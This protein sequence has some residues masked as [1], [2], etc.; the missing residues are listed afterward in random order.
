MKRKNKRIKLI[1]YLPNQHTFGGT[2]SFIFNLLKHLNKEQFQPIILSQARIKMLAIFQSINIPIKILNP[3]S[4]HGMKRLIN[5]IKEN[6]IS[7][8]QTNHFSTELA[9]ASYVAGI[10]HIWRPGGDIRLTK[11]F[12]DKKRRL[13]YFKILIALSNK[14]VCAS[15]FLKRQFKDINCSEIKVIYNGVEIKK[16]DSRM[17]KNNNYAIGMIAHLIPQKKHIDFIRAAEI[18][19]KELP[20]TKFY[21]I[22]SPYYSKESINYARLLKKIVKRKKLRKHIIFTGFINNPNKVILSLNATVMPS[23]DEGSSNAIIESLAL[24][25]P[26]IASRSGGNPELIADNINGFLVKPRN[27]IGLANSIIKILKNPKRAKTMGLK[28]RVVAKKLFDINKTVKVYQKL[29]SSTMAGFVSKNQS[30]TFS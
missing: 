6:K 24:G 18:V 26:V 17:P 3:Q 30:H 8:A 27:Y 13:D 20:Q 5:F 1:Y 21:I 22:G 10:P 15:Y 23:I 14:I 25:K 2:E 28:G 12:L 16:L 11:S 7:L 4:K 29:Y 9:K 19:L